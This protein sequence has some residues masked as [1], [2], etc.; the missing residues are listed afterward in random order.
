M[1]DGMKDVQQERLEMG[2][3]EE[4]SKGMV[5]VDELGMVYTMPYIYYNIVHMPCHDAMIYVLVGVHN[6]LIYARI[7]AHEPSPPSPSHPLSIQ[8]PVQ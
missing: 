4:D 5:A 2:S 7:R 3:S 8:I 1:F 6:A